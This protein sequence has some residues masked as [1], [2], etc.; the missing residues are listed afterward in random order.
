MERLFL[1]FI[2]KKLT[3]LDKLPAT[4]LPQNIEFPPLFVPPTKIL[5]KNS[6][7]LTCPV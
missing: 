5:E 4:E 3:S 6:P 2:N 7:P 1:Q